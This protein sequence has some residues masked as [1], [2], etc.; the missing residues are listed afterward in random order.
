MGKSIEELL[1]ER[2]ELDSQI[3]KARADSRNSA[4]A[5]I[6]RIIGNAGITVVELHKHF[7]LRSTG[8][9]DAKTKRAAP[10]V[11]YIDPANSENTWS[12]RGRAAKWLKAYLDQGKKLEDFLKA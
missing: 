4:F 8:T 6:E 9:G 11:K 7:P 10:A 1:R 12:G 5:E 3:E 2:A